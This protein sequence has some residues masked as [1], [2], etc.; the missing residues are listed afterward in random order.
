MA[1]VGTAGWALIFGIAGIVLV[2]LIVAIRGRKRGEAGGAEGE[3]AT[4]LSEA[5]TVDAP[6]PEQEED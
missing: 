6:S 3:G 4:G 5:E 1:A 2:G